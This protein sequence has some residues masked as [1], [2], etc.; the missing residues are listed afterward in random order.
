ME[1]TKDLG[2]FD[3]FAAG[4]FSGGSSLSAGEAGMVERGRAVLRSPP[5]KK[6]TILMSALLRQY[7]KVIS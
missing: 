1:I 6:P 4:I 2:P 7:V 5:S 3:R